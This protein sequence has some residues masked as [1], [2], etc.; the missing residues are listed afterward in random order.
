MAQRPL[1]VTQ[2]ITVLQP[3]D[4][5]ADPYSQYMPTAA[6]AQLVPASGMV[7][8]Q[9]GL[10]G[11]PS[12]GM[13]QALAVLASGVAAS[14]VMEQPELEL[15]AIPEPLPLPP[16]SPEPIAP[17]EPPLEVASLPGRPPSDGA[18]VLPPQPA[19]G[20]RKVAA[21][22]TAN[23][24][25]SRQADV[26]DHSPLAGGEYD[27]RTRLATQ[28]FRA[29]PGK[30]ECM[31]VLGATVDVRPRARVVPRCGSIESR[32]R[33]TAPSLLKPAQVVPYRRS[34]MTAPTPD[35]RCEVR[36]CVSV[37][38]SLERPD[39]KQRLSLLRDIST[40]GARM[41]VASN[42]LNVGDS[43]RLLLYFGDA[44]CAA[45]GQLLR[46]QRTEDAGIW[47]QEVAIR[48]DEP[49]RVDVDWVA[50]ASPD[51]LAS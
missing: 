22:P 24:A 35:R 33:L 39:G 23:V 37:V 44:D 13:P 50:S 14:T 34:P 16:P 28:G 1:V 48:F 40:S 41:M 30:G 2:Y 4:H 10:H 43:V 47:K 36:H 18:L 11:P 51:L 8:G 46:V 7:S 26:I 6:G 15:P 31:T 38:A 49:L 27:M 12:G 9:M 42:K 45:S 3:G 29:T 20:M 17:L 19:T 21:L 25:P 5:Q 32:S